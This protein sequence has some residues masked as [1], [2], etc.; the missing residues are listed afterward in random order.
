M[1]TKHAVL[2]DFLVAIGLKDREPDYG[3][4]AFDTALGTLSATGAVGSGAGL[5]GVGTYTPEGLD[6]PA[7]HLVNSPARSMDP[8]FSHLGSADVYHVPLASLPQNRIIPASKS[9]IGRAYDR[10]TGGHILDSPTMLPHRYNSANGGITNAI[11]DAA[12]MWPTYAR[13]NKLRTGAALAG[14]G[15]SISGALAS[16]TNVADEMGWL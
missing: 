3:T 16:G 15:L 12:G 14:L 9:A 2:D 10:L 8:V 4:V 1:E 13:N 7:G 11:V 6:T 5:L